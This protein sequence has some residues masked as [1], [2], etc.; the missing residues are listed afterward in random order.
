MKKLICLVV[1]AFLG[2]SNSNAQEFIKF[3]A[4]GGVN[5]TN[6]T[7]D[8]FDDENSRTGFHLGLLVEIPFSDRISIQPEV[9]YSTQGVN[10]ASFTESGSLITSD[11]ELDYIQVP[12][13]AKLYLIQ[14][15]AVEVGPSF[16]F[17]VK[18]EAELTSSAGS[19]LI[20]SDIAE[21][22]EF[23][24]AVGLSYNF[25]GGFFTSARY[26]QGF[27]DI[28]ENANIEDDARN[29]GIQLGIGYMF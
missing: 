12:V 15:L 22:F 24:G 7:T 8:G 16:N 3:G 25:R 1:I 28:F 19:L 2:F 6:I 11:F 13:M 10:D 18:E 21:S 5:F 29:N 9:L 20:D 27:S 26:T 4:K 17:L 23:G 14:G